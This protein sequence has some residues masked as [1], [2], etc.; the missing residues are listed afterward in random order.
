MLIEHEVDTAPGVIALLLLFISNDV[1]IG[2]DALIV[3]QN[4]GCSETF[5]TGANLA[6]LPMR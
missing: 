1:S 6:L 3:P 2:Q 4:S 5:R